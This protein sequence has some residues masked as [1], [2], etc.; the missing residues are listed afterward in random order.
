MKKSNRNCFLHT[1]FSYVLL[2]VRQDPGGV[3]AESIT[4]PGNRPAA[5]PSA[6]QL[7]E[8]PQ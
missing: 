6:H 8:T 7:I 5:A 1:W 4:R 3:Q 2:Y